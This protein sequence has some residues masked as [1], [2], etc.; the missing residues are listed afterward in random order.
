MLLTITTTA[1]NASDLGYLLHKNPATLFEKPLTFGTAR[2]FYAEAT[3]ERCT[4]CLQVV[5]D[6]VGLVRGK[7][8][9]AGG[10]PLAQYVSDRPYAASSFLSVALA[11]CFGTA[12]SGRSKEKQERVEEKIPLSATIHALKAAPDLVESLFAPL[13][14]AVE[15][16]RV[17]PLDTHFP[18]WGES[19]LVDVTLSAETTVR[20]L[21]THLYVL[22]PTLDNAKHYF[23]GDDEVEKLLRRGA[24]WLENH[25]AKETIALRYLRYRK[26]LA[27]EALARLVEVEGSDTPEAEEAQETTA[28]VAEEKLENKTSLNTLRIAATIAAIAAMSPPAKRVIDM[29]CG[30]GRT[31]QAVL[32]QVKG[33]EHVAGMD[34]AT[35]PLE[36]AARRLHLDRLNEREQARVAL[37]HGSLVYKD[38]RL[39][40]F[41]AALLNEVIEHL[42]AE[43]VST[44]ARVVF[45]DARP[46]RVIVTTPN[47]EYNSVW[48]TLPAGKFRHGDH[49][50]EWTRAE[51]EQWAHQT[52][53]AH[54]YTVAFIGVGAEDKD[55]GRGFPTQMAVFDGKGATD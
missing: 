6:A 4:V 41:D 44:L 33:V 40:G 24:G 53:A 25:P 55:G 49:R 52:A 13:G 18:E 9:S 39:R 31:M 17:G 34:V 22:I 43:R 47:A 26:G 46:R 28:E 50:F 20:D 23:I 51:F 14:Y 7:G 38:E 2:I 21:L 36:K 16:V 37:F 27:K 35:V 3:E 1:D 5:V 48:E 19:G 30:E 15:S 8:D 11:E 12:L 45:A 42:D 29:G 32:A 10:T 54:G